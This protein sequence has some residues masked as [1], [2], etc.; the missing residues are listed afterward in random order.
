[1]K[2]SDEKYTMIDACFQVVERYI[3]EHSGK[4]I[5]IQPPKTVREAELFIKA[6]DISLLYYNLKL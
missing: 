4:L 1:M 3:Y 5:T 2:N 6:L